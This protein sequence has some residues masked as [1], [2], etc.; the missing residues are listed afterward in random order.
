MAAIAI[1]K[2]LLPSDGRF[3][4]GPSKVRPEALAA[5]AQR[6]AGIIGT[7]HRQTPVRDLVGRVRAM[8]GE[9]FSLPDGYEI[10]LGNGGS[11]C[12]WDIAT[13]CLIQD[14]SQH[15]TFG[16]FS[17]KFAEGVE[18]APHLGAPAVR[19]APYGERIGPEADERVDAYALIQN[20]T[21][22]GVAV[23]PQRP[24]HADGSPARGLVL[25]DGTSA[26]GGMRIRLEETDAYYFAPQKCFGSD[27]GLWL[28]ALSPAAIERAERLVSERYVPAF[29]DLT[30]A[31]ENARLNQTYNTPAIV[32]LLLLADQLEWMLTNGGLEWAAQRAERSAAHLYDWAERSDVATP[33]VAKADDRSPVVATI[34]IAAEID[35]A[36]IAKTLRDNGVVDTEPYRRLG[37]NQLRIGMYPTVDP[38]DVVALTACIDHVVA[39]LA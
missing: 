27:G 12:F 33:F 38:D 26:A 39:A 6:G 7:S 21:S 5:L 3:G 10:V 2:A 31:I 22:T 37:R 15:C 34:D 28:A 17:A 32:T 30:A 29:L 19:S 23:A 18:R 16:E 11:A 9:L 13:F 20:E 4:S 35:A 8:L 14:K 36:A 24:R 25:V 1:P